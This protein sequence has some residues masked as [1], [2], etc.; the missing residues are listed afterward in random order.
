MFSQSCV[1]VYLVFVY[2]KL[3]C[4]VCLSVFIPVSC[5]MCI[6]LSFASP[7]PL[8]RFSSPVF[9]GLWQN[10]SK[11]EHSICPRFVN[12][13]Q[14]S[15]YKNKSLYLKLRL[16]VWL[17]LTFKQMHS[18]TQTKDKAMKSSSFD[19]TLNQ[20][21]IVGCYWLLAPEKQPIKFLKSLRTSVG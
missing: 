13:T 9:R 16:F 18:R 15:N 2:V 1:H 17:Q 12:F 5:L 7:V 21:M 3:V 8:I 19:C 20:N 11:Q 10:I 6:V 14:S 4:F